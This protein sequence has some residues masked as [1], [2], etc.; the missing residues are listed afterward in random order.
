[1]FAATFPTDGAIYVF[2]VAITSA[3]GS[4]YSTQATIT[5]NGECQLANCD[6]CPEL[7]ECVICSAHA[8]LLIST[9]QCQ[10]KQPHCVS[11]KSEPCTACESGFSIFGGAC[12]A[13]DSP[14]PAL[15]TATIATAGL[16]VGVSSAT[17]IATTGAAG[18]SFWIVLNSLQAI[19]MLALVNLDYPNPL[20]SFFD[21]F[22]FALL[23]FPEEWNP[24][25]NIDTSKFTSGEGLEDLASTGG[26]YS[27]YFV[28]QQFAFLLT[29]TGIGLLWINWTLL[30]RWAEKPV[31]LNVQEEFVQDNFEGGEEEKLPLEE[32][33]GRVGNRHNYATDE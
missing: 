11:C 27:T 30:L 18:A 32:K 12:L 7:T 25:N 26:F 20:I 24:L 15:T 23:S 31:K 13:D 1:M 10:C 29:L 14:V 4:T 22:E 3:H 33:K 5:V 28:V 8:V 19:E 2:Q 6:S 9:N 17:S 21:G 16:A